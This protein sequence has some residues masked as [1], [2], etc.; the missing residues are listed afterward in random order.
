MSERTRRRPMPTMQRPIQAPRPHEVEPSHG[1]AAMIESMRAFQEPAWSRDLG[2]QAQV[3]PATADAARHLGLCD[4]ETDR[5]C[6]E[7]LPETET[8]R[9]LLD[10]AE[11]VRRQTTP[12]PHTSAD[13][14]GPQGPY[15]ER[16]W[17]NDLQHLDVGDYG[18]HLHLLDLQGGDDVAT[19][20]GPRAALHVG[21]IEERDS[22]DDPWQ[23]GIRA[24]GSLAS[25]TMGD[26][27]TGVDVNTPHAEAEASFGERGLV[28]DTGGSVLDA[29][30][31]ARFEDAGDT[32]FQ[33]GLGAEAR[34]ALRVPIEDT[35]RDG[36]PEV[37]V[38]VTAGIGTLGFTTEG[39]CQPD[40]PAR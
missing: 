20:R 10:Q 9:A 12:D 37:G 30:G 35:D 25:V 21:Q 1:N 2:R 3:D 6:L 24:E 27:D 40:R 33:Y 28:L 5:A 13:R 29:D 17:G 39:F 16:V 32:R 15:R 19:A 31:R 4:I 18:A 14:P 34:T 26:D 7:R 22:D 38:Q 36:C 11:A 23:F 8:G